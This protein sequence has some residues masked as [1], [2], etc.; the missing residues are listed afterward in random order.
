[1]GRGAQA[2]R[3]LATPRAR[4]HLGDFAAMWTGADGILTADKQPSQFPAD[5][6]S[7]RA[8]MRTETAQ[9]FAHVVFDGTHR[10]DE[11]YTAN[12]SFVSG[13]LAT[14]YGL[15]APQ[16]T[17]SRI[18]YPDGSRSGILGHASILGTAAH[19]D[20]SSPIRRGLFVRRNLLCQELPPPPPDVGSAPQV[21]PHAT[22]RER[23]AQHT[24]NPA[25]A[26]CHRHIDPVGFGFERFDALGRL[27]DSEN[28]RPVDPAG[29]MTDVEALGAGTSAPFQ[30][31]AALGRTLAGSKAAHACLA[32]QAY[33][34]T[35][36]LLEQDPCVTLPYEEHLRQAGGDIREL[37][38]ELVSSNDFAERR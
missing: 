15:A 22:T 1:A 9:L 27:R 8:A 23:F 29:D 38:V 5:S 30:D 37:L 16:A 17:P 7:L 14:H 11:L 24:S 10:V 18:T 33:R 2:R 31:L 3:L 34:F 35:R 25:C 21:D 32:R 4:T 26:S 20:Q 19:S 12:Y 28:G 13:E 36:G 6:A